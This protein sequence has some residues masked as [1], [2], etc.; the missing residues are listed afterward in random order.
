[1]KK[2]IGLFLLL[3]LMAF[4]QPFLRNW[5]TTNANPVPTIA[6]GGT[7]QTTAPLARTALDVPSL[8]T[9]SN[10]WGTN[11]NTFPSMQTSVSTNVYT[12]PATVTQAHNSTTV[13]STGNVFA[14]WPR[15]GVSFNQGGVN[16]FFV[17]STNNANQLTA[18]DGF[19]G[20]GFTNSA[21]QV[22]LPLWA[23]YD[24]GFNQQA[25]IGAGG[26]FG[27]ASGT[28]GQGFAD[29]GYRIEDGIYSTQLHMF[30]VGGIFGEMLGF[31]SDNNSGNPPWALSPLAPNYSYIMLPN[32][33]NDFRVG[34]TND[35]G[36]IYIS[37]L[38]QQQGATNKPHG[39][40]VLNGASTVAVGN[41]LVTATTQI[42]FNEVLPNGGT[43]SGQ[44]I[45]VSVTPNTGFSV[46]SIALDTSIC[47]YWLV[48]T[49]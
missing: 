3:P 25:Y 41:T 29:G 38:I 20:A 46:K 48:N 35:L 31:G 18:S 9:A 36:A 33:V 8:T 14:G 30:A 22:Y 17:S 37:S 11:G 23:F 32:G 15:Y 2:L 40:F 45:P 4:G 43:A 26:M 21:V 6:Q 19:Q 49:N 44:I 28:F 27:T 42:H 12:T 39:Q 13:T 7:G 5:A 1:M 24:I 10:Q 47:E 34:I 16:Q